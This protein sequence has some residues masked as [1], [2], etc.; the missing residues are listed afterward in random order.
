MEKNQRIEELLMKHVK[1]ELSEQEQNELN[2]WVNEAEQHK[3]MYDRITNDEQLAQRV[4]QQGDL[5]K[6]IWFKITTGIPE[7]RARTVYH[8]WRR[9]TAAAAV[10]TIVLVGGYF[11]LNSS[12][13]RDITKTPTTKNNNDVEPGTEKAVLTL[14]DGTKITLDNTVNG[15]IAE[16]GNTVVMKEDGLLAYNTDKNKI[17]DK[18]IFN[19][20]TTGKSEEYKSLVLSDGTKVWL[21]SLS[22]IHFPTA[23]IEKE[24]TVEITGEAYFEV[25]KNISHPF[26]V[27]VN[28]MEIE[29]LGTHFNVNAYSDEPIIRTTLLEGSVKVSKDRN[30]KIIKPGQQAQITAGNGN[31][32]ITD[33]DVEQV[34][35]WK[36][37]FF[38]FDNN[39]IETIMRQIARWYDVDVVYEGKTAGRFSGRVS[40]N[41]KLS[42]V[43]KAF[44]ESNIHFKIQGKTIT[45]IP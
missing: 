13:Q 26:K 36:S 24:R 2:E 44:Q 6:T 21:N 25:A 8:N 17:Q 5:K 23:F 18:I 35:A 19:T 16:Q 34:V 14:A 7:L 15:A 31:I 3:A 39:D 22:S 1:E 10:L 12:K 4:A 32:Q 11:W 37:G 28:G 27:S 38:V 42:E 33:A 45:V 41:T 29:V 30:S 9:F 43:L 40:R 20:L